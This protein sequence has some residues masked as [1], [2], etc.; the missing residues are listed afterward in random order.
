MISLHSQGHTRVGSASIRALCKYHSCKSANRIRPR[1][2]TQASHR[3]NWLLPVK[4][5]SKSSTPLFA[6][7]KHIPDM[8]PEN[9]ANEIAKTTR[10]RSIER[11]VGF[12]GLDERDVP[13]ALWSKS[14]VRSVA[15]E[16]SVGLGMTGAMAETCVGR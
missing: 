5:K 2:R 12:I 16:P 4:V 11:R 14:G 8:M 10:V 15:S 7:S 9:D 6:K 3:Q 1:T 13:P